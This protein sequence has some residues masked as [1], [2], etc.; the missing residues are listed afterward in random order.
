[1]KGIT[2]GIKKKCEEEEMYLFHKWEERWK[3]EVQEDDIFLEWYEK[4]YIDIWQ[5]KIKNERR[6]FRYKY[7][8]LF[9]IV[10]FVVVLIWDNIKNEGKTT[11]VLCSLGERGTIFLV[12]IVVAAVILNK[13]LEIKKFQ[14]TWVRHSVHQQKLDIEMLKFIQK[15]GQYGRIIQGD[16]KESKSLFVSNVLRIEEENIE[17]FAKNMKHEEKLMDIFK[18]VKESKKVIR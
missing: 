17:K 3:K 13:L 5:K 6:N 14:E 18:Y 15:I 10:I 12:I 4:M 7:A 8:F 9:F 2:W 16:W 1:M 11:G